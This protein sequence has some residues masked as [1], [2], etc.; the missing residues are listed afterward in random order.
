[1]LSSPK[2]IRQRSTALPLAC[3]LWKTG[4]CFLRK[5]FASPRCCITCIILVDRGFCRC[6]K[7]GFESSCDVVLD[8]GLCRETDSGFETTCNVFLVP[9]LRKIVDSGFETI[10]DVF[11]DSGL[12]KSARFLKSCRL[13]EQEKAPR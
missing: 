6:P 4:K 7:S 3:R 1:M 2:T 8:S 10:S 13:T 5:S 9:G 11:L 12:F